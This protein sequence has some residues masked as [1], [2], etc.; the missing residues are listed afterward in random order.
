GVSAS[1]INQG[2]AGDCY[3]IAA[4]SAV[5]GAQ[6]Q[7]IRSAI[8]L[9]R[10]NK[11]GTAIYGVR[12]Y[13]PSAEGPP[14]PV[15]IHVTTKVYFDHGFLGLGQSPTYSKAPEAEMWP[16]LMEKAFAQ[17]KRSY[18]AIGQGGT[19]DEPLFALTGKPQ[20][21]KTVADMPDADLMGLLEE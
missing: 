15:T 2:A 20:S 6:P 19:S 8:K 7:V 16:L 14:H 10:E 4:L 18:E 21:L 13:V 9:E 12:L 5:A 1:D 17:Y 11:D 3:L